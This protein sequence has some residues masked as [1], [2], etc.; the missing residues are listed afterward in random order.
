MV[1]WGNSYIEIYISVCEG[2]LTTY[3][4]SIIWLRIL[5]IAVHSLDDW[6]RIVYYNFDMLHGHKPTT[7]IRGYNGLNCILAWHLW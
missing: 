4:Y 6:E 1:L 5:N 2:N 3:I 7:I